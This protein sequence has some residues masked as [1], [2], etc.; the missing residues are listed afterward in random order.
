[1]EPG[2]RPRIRLLNRDSTP[3][4]AP[5]QRRERPGAIQHLHDRTGEQESLRICSNVLNVAPED[6][7]ID[8]PV[9]VT[10]APAADQPGRFRLLMVY[11]D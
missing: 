11:M 7:H 9:Q 6:I 5:S 4:R 3:S 2:Q 1:M 10:F 8:M